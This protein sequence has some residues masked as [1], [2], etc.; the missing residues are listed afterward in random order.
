MKVNKSLMK[1]SKGKHYT[2]GLFLEIGYTKFSMYTLK[3]EDHTYKGVVYPSIK[4]LYLDYEDPTEYEFAKTYFASWNHWQAICR[5]K[6]LAVHI[7]EW[8]DELELKIQSQAIRDIIHT[9]SEGSY[10]ASKF[11]ADRGWSKNAVGRPNKADKAKK[12]AVDSI[13]ENEFSNDFTRMDI[14]Q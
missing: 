4:K 7:N 12:D 8:R 6:V 10:Q 9:S 1:D 2:Q 14:V 13:I 11:L 3:E 5:N